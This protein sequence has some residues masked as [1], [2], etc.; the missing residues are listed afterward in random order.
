MRSAEPSLATRQLTQKTIT[1]PRWKT[2]TVK[3]T[4]GK[5]TDNA[6]EDRLAELSARV[7]A[8]AEMTPDAEEQTV[9]RRQLPTPTPQYSQALADQ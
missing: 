5:R 9:R 2:P 8:E 3:L 4:D 6:K 7:M 1:P